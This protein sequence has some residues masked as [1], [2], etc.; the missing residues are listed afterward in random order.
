MRYEDLIIDPNLE[1]ADF[2][3]FLDLP[4]PKINYSLLVKSGRNKKHD[5]RETP[6]DIPL[7]NTMLNRFCYS[8]ETATIADGD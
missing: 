1:M 4:I 8:K 7:V 3:K 6:K 2:F 5:K